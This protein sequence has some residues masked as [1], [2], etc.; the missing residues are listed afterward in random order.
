MLSDTTRR[1]SSPDIRWPQT[2][3]QFSS[4]FGLPP[5]R[6]RPQSWI[7][8][9]GFAFKILIAKGYQK[10]DGRISAPTG[11]MKAEL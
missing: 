4:S 6:T 9:Q 7:E 8:K 10:K 5:I 2:L 1:T 11:C 3:A